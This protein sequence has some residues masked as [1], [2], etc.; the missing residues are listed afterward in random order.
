MRAG[1]PPGTPLLTLAEGTNLSS[2]AFTLMFQMAAES[3]GRHLPL[4]RYDIDSGT[5]W[6]GPSLGAAALPEEM[7]PFSASARVVVSAAPSRGTWA[8]GALVWA[9]VPTIQLAGWL[10]TAAGTP[11]EWEAFGF[12]TQRGAARREAK[13]SAGP[14]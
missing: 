12:A 14:S 1:A 3:F 13:S 4:L 6:N 10:C 9:A 2:P 7:L 11:G 8:E 5:N